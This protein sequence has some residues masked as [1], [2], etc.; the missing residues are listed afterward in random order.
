MNFAIFSIVI[1]DAYFA[2][3]STAFFALA[4][5][6]KLAEIGFSAATANTALLAGGRHRTL[7]LLIH[8][9]F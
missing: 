5:D 3:R 8:V 4:A 9:A 7:T 6:G 2:E 1:F